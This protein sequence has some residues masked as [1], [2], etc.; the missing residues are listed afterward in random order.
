M[1][2]SRNH[3]CDN[4]WLVGDSAQWGEASIPALIQVLRFVVEDFNYLV[5]VSPGEQLLVHPDLNRG[6]PE[7]CR[8][9]DGSFVIFLS[10]RGDNNWSQFVYQ[11]AH[12]YCHRLIGGPMDGEV[13]TTFWFEES[14]CE[15]SSMVLLRRMAERWNSISV[16][17]LDGEDASEEE[18][19]LSSLKRFAPINIPYLQRLLRKN[20]P[21]I[22]PLHEW[23]N[24]NMSVLSEREYHRSLY[25]QFACVLYGLFSLFPSLWKVLPF[26]YRP[27]TADYSGFQSFIT[28]TV[29]GRMTVSIANYP[30]FVMILTGLDFTE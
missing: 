29:P 15:M 20:P 2:L 1:K 23:L 9:S 8:L 26:L 4:V 30:L 21:I 18:I 5:G 17:V 3:V 28:D 10:A 16:T 12:E 19:A 14:V 7:C 27:A 6:Y 25:N 24:S 13:E 11:F 22:V